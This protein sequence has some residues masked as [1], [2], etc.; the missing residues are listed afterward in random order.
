MADFELDENDA[1]ETR[2]GEISNSS[3]VNFSPNNFFSEENV[4]KIKDNNLSFKTVKFKD[5]TEEQQRNVSKQY[6][7]VNDEFEFVMMQTSMNAF[8]YDSAEKIE[9][10]RLELGRQYKVST[11][12]SNALGGESSYSILVP[13][14]EV[15]EQNFVKAA[16]N[17]SIKAIEDFAFLASIL[18]IEPKVYCENQNEVNAELDFIKKTFGNEFK[19][20]P[21]F[22]N[23]LTALIYKD[24]S[25]IFRYITTATEVALGSYILTAGAVAAITFAATNPIGWIALGILAFGVAGTNFDGFL[26]D[27]TEDRSSNRNLERIMRGGVG[28]SLEGMDAN[29][30]KDILRYNT[31]KDFNYENYFES[32]GTSD[33]ID[34]AIEYFVEE[35][36]MQSSSFKLLESLASDI[37]VGAR[38]SEL[39]RSKNTQSEREADKKTLNIFSNEVIGA[40]ISSFLN[41]IL[42]FPSLSEFGAD[43]EDAVDVFSINVN[44][45]VTSNDI[46]ASLG[47][48]GYY[49]SGEK[50]GTGRY[51]FDYQ[52][53]NNRYEASTAL[54]QG[55]FS[56]NKERLKEQNRKTIAYLKTLLDSLLE[57]V[58]VNNF[59]TIAETDPALARMLGEQDVFSLLEDSAY[60]DIITPKDPVIARFKDSANRLPID[61]YYFKIN[62][63]LSEMNE[64]ERSRG[65]KI[66]T[67]SLDF[68]KNIKDKG[69]ISK[70]EEKA[71][72]I[73][74]SGILFNFGNL[75]YDNR[76]AEIKIDN[77]DPNSTDGNNAKLS[78]LVD[79]KTLNSVPENEVE[80]YISELKAHYE[81]QIKN[82]KEALIKLRSNFGSKFAYEN[83]EALSYFEEESSAVNDEKFFDL[84]EDSFLSLKESEGM[85][86][87]FPTFRLYL[88]EEDAIYSDRLLAFDDF[89]Y[90]NSV[91]SFN[92]HSD[93]E[94]AT[95]T[96]SIQL[97]NISGLLDGT[98]KGMLRDIDIG[99]VNQNA[100]EVLPTIESVVLRKGVNVQ[101]RAGYASNTN[102][103]DVLISGVVTEISYSGDNMLCNIVVQSY[104]I[105]LESLKYGTSS[106]AEINNKFYSTHQL[107]GTLLLSPQLKHFGRVKTGKLFQ[108]FESKIPSIDMETYTRSGGWSFN[109]FNSWNDWIVDNSGL[110]LI[111]GV[112]LS[113]GARPLKIL[114]DALGKTAI[115][116]KVGS[117]I[118]AVS[119]KL[120]S[121]GGATKI[122]GPIV[123][124]VGSV[125]SKAFNMTIKPLWQRMNNWGGTR[126]VQSEIDDLVKL[127][128][129][130][131][132]S[133]LTTVT[134]SVGSTLTINGISL[135]A[136]LTKKVAD[137]IARSGRRVSALT[138]PQINSVVQTVIREELGFLTA[139]FGWGGSRAFAAL[140]ADV[141]TASA[142]SLTRLQRFS[143]FINSWFWPAA[144]FAGK[145]VLISTAIGIPLLATDTL[146]NLYNSLLSFFNESQR[147]YTRKILIS[148]QDDNLWCPRPESYLKRNNENNS[149]LI[150]AFKK[151]YYSQSN[152]VSNS[153]MGIPGMFI[154]LQGDS[155]SSLINDAIRKSRGFIDERLD[156]SRFENEYVV[157]SQTFWEV[158]HEMS[159]RHPGY[160]YGVR[161]YGK[162]MEYRVFFGL[163]G[164]RYFRNDMS[165]YNIYRLN[166]IYKKISK[167]NQN[168]LL[169]EEDINL[170]FPI[171]SF[172]W[173]ILNKKNNILSKFIDK[174]KY[175]TDFALKDWLKKTKDRF[176][177]FRQ[178]HLVNSGTNLIANNIIVSG[179]NVNNSITVH[180]SLMSNSNDVS[181]VDG[182]SVWKAVAN[183]NIPP[184]SLRDHVLKTDNIKGI[185]NASRYAT[186]G[187]LYGAKKMYEGSLLVLGNSK[188]NTNDAIILND[189]VN[190]M[191]GPVGVK[192]VTHM[193]SHQTGFVTDIE[194]E[195]IVAPVSDTLTYPMLH[196]TVF[197]ESRKELY[198]SFYS[199]AAFNYVNE[200]N[201]KIAEIVSEKIDDFFDSL[202]EGE[203]LQGIDFFQRGNVLDKEVLN[204]V[205]AQLTK[206]FIQYFENKN[207]YQ[208]FFQQDMI[209]ENARLPV[210]LESPIRKTL[211]VGA[212]TTA[213]ITGLEAAIYQIFKTN[214]INYMGATRLTGRI[215]FLVGATLT[216]L[217]SAGA[218]MPSSIRNFLS[219]SLQSGWLGKNI[220]RPTIF[221]KV[222]NNNIIKVFPLVK[223]GRPLLAGGFENHSEAE[224]FNNVLG[225]IY[226]ALS[227][228]YKGY[229]ENKHLIES[230]G[231]SSVFADIP[232][233]II[234]DSVQASEVDLSVINY[235]LNPERVGR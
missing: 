139:T 59:D 6:T 26:F 42:N 161:P 183:S 88:V 33:E 174:R 25:L 153:F 122:F 158:L 81:T 134:G 171:E 146:V 12:G 147:P 65:N 128:D 117:G 132:K 2:D 185:S 208:P 21:S 198:E 164:Q 127:A 233:W 115:I 230:Y 124:N 87:A 206:E 229:N 142:T 152:L 38:V 48:E 172:N 30:F 225:N 190:V 163:P 104:G 170:L 235:K 184:E 162:T 84:C 205:K 75:S 85:K 156:T 8:T 188:I 18:I 11:I 61:F 196:Q 94:L 232:D 83:Q 140:G 201:E 96:A 22:Y 109:W 9:A 44:G 103:L 218:L 95:S 112:I 40:E 193:F 74:D 214:G 34:K 135:S 160:V 204:K 114:K 130:L 113:I 176:V 191:Y 64:N 157:T 52:L 194:V 15:I 56:K 133:G 216:G 138:E 37:K 221:S 86:K 144:R 227:D 120:T 76:D 68:I 41:F 4:R 199:R 195:A 3:K 17:I 178:Y 168:E 154:D 212:A 31:N 23:Y 111:G 50:V 54:Q 36:Y 98:R 77:N 217:L 93:R 51:L 47:E 91:I 228:G 182:T 131:A 177:P 175:F 32:V 186:A 202:L 67:K 99:N 10:I 7:E 24:E 211:G 123:G 234:E 39:L 49:Q 197:F 223:D 167:L 73:F 14:I 55:Y 5:L 179:H 121:L 110:I 155:S 100:E 224:R 1:N 102:D 45:T 119:S 207:G 141:V 220:F 136:N 150:T 90:Y 63:Y 28:L 181:E 203:D 29:Y 89:F 79:N 92:V 19:I 125:T 219:E 60:P 226:S 159:L 78:L 116:G 149:G 145:N 173:T 62:N 58:A 107:L 222:D 209:G 137:V 166:N 189:N 165:N 192:A 106:K 70:S 20:V 126:L 57:E 180:Y 231:K 151:Y 148:P 101:L 169:S 97:Q 80:N 82:Q 53:E 69:V 13:K 210:E 118:N 71:V 108:T 143:N 200:G 35:V 43:E 105:E 66:L 187:L 27:L 16:T 213:G 72:S 129:D 46:Y 215:P